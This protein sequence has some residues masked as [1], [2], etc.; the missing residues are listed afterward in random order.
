MANL[1]L[2]D[3]K[4]LRMWPRTLFQKKEGKRLRIKLEVPEMEC[5]GVY[6]LYKGDELYYVGRAARLMSRLHDHANKVTDDY[7][8]HWD[9]FSAFVLADT[10]PKSASVQKLVELEAILIAAMPRATNKSTPRFTRV[11]IPKSL[12]YDD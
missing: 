12:R 3:F 2:Q 11:T 8:A 9:Y 6:V 10:V 1:H 4:F 7:Y 5:P